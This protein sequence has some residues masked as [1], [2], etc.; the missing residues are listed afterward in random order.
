M[1]K[2][3]SITTKKVR[4]S[5]ASKAS[6]RSLWETTGSAMSA[7]PEE[8]LGPDHEDDR[9]D[10]EDHGVRGLGKEH[11][12][13][14]LDDPEREARDDGPQDRPMPPITTTAN[15]TMMRSAPMSGPTW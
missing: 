8:A 11:L 10:H 13:K 1:R 12:R 5:R 2:K 14:A 9:H 15:T 3:A 7:L 6:S 4:C